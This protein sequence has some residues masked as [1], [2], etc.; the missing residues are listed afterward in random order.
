MK[1]FK[2]IPSL[3]L[4]IFLACSCSQIF[5]AGFDKDVVVSFSSNSPL[6]TEKQELSWSTIPYPA[7]G[8]NIVTKATFIAQGVKKDTIHKVH[9]PVLA[10]QK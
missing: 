9:Q 3:V 6:G 4:F 7:D 1:I 2:F 10:L 5:Y 8:F